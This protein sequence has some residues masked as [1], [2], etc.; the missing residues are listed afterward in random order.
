MEEKLR[1]VLKLIKE[2]GSREDLELKEKMVRCLVSILDE[3]GFNT[4]IILEKPG[5]GVTM[6]GNKISGEG[7]SAPLADLFTDHPRLFRGVMFKMAMM[8]AFEADHEEDDASTLGEGE[9]IH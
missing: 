3:A 2:S 5:V 4:L 6:L 1:K 9:T 7:I 8:K